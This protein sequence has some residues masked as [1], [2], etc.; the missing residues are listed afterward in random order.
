M[1][2]NQTI[3]K[4]SFILIYAFLFVAALFIGTVAAKDDSISI[5]GNWSGLYQTPGPSGSLEI[6]LTDIESKLSG[7]V[8]IEGPG[9]KILTKPAQNLKVDGNNIKFMIEI[10]G[11]EITFS[12]KLKD[13]KLTG[14]LEAVE[15]GKTVGMG[16]WEMTHSQR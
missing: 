2:Q 12:G 5:I 7:E 1:R 9:S 15:N 14:E 8:K 13:G 3:K 6:T 10:M 11:A 16:S 4:R